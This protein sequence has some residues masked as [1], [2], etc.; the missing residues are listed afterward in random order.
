MPAA[1]VRRLMDRLAGLRPAQSGRPALIEGSVNPYTV[2]AGAAADP[3][4]R[5]F[6][7]SFSA[8]MKVPD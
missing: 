1:L 5:A 6:D 7:L 2:A 3:I 4:A 8:M